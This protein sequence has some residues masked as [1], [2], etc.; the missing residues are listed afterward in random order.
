[1]DKINV[2]EQFGAKCFELGEMK[3]LKKIEIFVYTYDDRM[4][5]DINNILRK[6][7]PDLTIVQDRQKENFFVPAYPY[8]KQDSFSGFW[9]I[10]CNRFKSDGQS[11]FDDEKDE[12]FEAKMSRMSRSCAMST[13]KNTK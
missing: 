3:K 6:N 7:L 10:C 13:K 1:M 11:E 4:Q 2:H 8:A 5:E 12:Q 9:E